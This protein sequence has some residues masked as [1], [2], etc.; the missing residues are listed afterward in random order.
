MRLVVSCLAAPIALITAASF[1]VAQRRSPL[2][3]TRLYAGTDGQAQAG[4]T[5][6]DMRP[7]ALRAGLDESAPQKVSAAQ[8][9][10][11][12][13]GTVWEWHTAVRKQYVVTVSGRGEV[14][15]DGGKKFPLNPGTVLL[16]EDVTGK[17]HTTRVLGSEDLVLLIIPLE[18]R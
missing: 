10:R 13:A 4:R 5:E 15:V 12:P 18:G 9:F 1:V 6:V 3:F 2:T 11:W 7:S 17:G 8:F 16:A 14:E